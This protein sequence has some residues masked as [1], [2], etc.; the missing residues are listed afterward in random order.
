[1]GR[2]R[3]IHRSMGAVHER[4]QTPHLAISTA[5]MLT[6]IVCLLI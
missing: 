5:A 4:H 6:A 2:Y 3:F 1:M